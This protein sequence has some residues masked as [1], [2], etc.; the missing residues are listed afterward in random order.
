MKKEE[1][2]GPL[3]AQ[4]EKAAPLRKAA[5]SVRLCEDLG[6]GSRTASTATSDIPEGCRREARGSWIPSVGL[7]CGS[8]FGPPCRFR[9]PGFSLPSVSWSPAVPVAG[10]RCDSPFRPSSSGRLLFRWFGSYSC[11]SAAQGVL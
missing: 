6:I 5:P 1:R 4:S 8:F 3:Q 7:Q 9:L 2:D 11:W 10:S